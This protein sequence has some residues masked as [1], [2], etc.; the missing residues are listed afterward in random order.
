M[1]RWNNRATEADK[2]VEVGCSSHESI[3]TGRNLL[4][5]FNERGIW[6]TQGGHPIK[7]SRRVQRW[8]D[9]MSSSFY[10]NVSGYC[11][12]DYYYCSIGDVTM[13]GVT[14]NNIVLRYT[15]DTKEWAVFSYANEFRVFASYISGTD[16]LT[17]G[18]DTTAR[19]LRLNNG[20]ID[21]GTGTD[22]PISF[23]VES[24]DV[25]FGSRGVVKTISERIMAYGI[26][27][28]NV[29]VSVQVDNG[30]WDDI[31]SMSTLVNELRNINIKGHFFRF[32]ITG[33][34][35]S[36]PFSFQGLELPHVE[37]HGYAK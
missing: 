11:D 2:V 4:F 5:F 26:N 30:D 27:P 14:Y 7:I 12:N 6:V 24:H 25:D 19:V 22:V 36:T 32:K 8:I 9:N 18:G 29:A 31:G 15:L 35:R 20:N 3:A 21:I 1:Y 28:V 34:S 23:E 33:A 10:E 37:T 17:L 13:D 16:V